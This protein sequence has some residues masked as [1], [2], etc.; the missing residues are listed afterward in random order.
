MIVPRIHLSSLLY[1]KI[2]ERNTEFTPEEI[3]QFKGALVD[4]ADRIRKC[5]DTL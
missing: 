3:L 5:A 2:D 4:P 1:D